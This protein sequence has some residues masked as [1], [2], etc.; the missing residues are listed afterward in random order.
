M[1]SALII[2]DEPDIGQAVTETLKRNNIDSTTVLDG[3]EG[4]DLAMTGQYDL[5]VLDLLLPSRNGFDIC[6]TLRSAGVSTPI[7][8]LSAKAGDFD[9]IEALEMGADDYLRKPFSVDVLAARVSALMRRPRSTADATMFAGIKY[10]SSSR[11]VQLDD[12]ERVH[13]T[14]REGQVLSLL[15]KAGDRPLSKGELLSKVWG[16]EYSGNP[17]VVEV[18]I[19]YLRKK[20]GRD[21]VDTIPRTGYRLRSDR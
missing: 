9:E 16:A 10:D 19:R 21:R 2:D 3:Q 17:N 20:L 14:P 13:L 7:I 4:L 1:T 18:Y 12:E 5:I 6:R 11:E 8:C 15:I